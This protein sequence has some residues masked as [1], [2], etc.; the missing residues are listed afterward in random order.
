M[1]GKDVNA[2][3]GSTSSGQKRQPES[4]TREYLCFRCSGAGPGKEETQ[5]TLPEK[6]KVFWGGQMREHGPWGGDWLGI[7]G[8]RLPLQLAGSTVCEGRGQVKEA[9][10]LVFCAGGGTRWE[11]WGQGRQTMK[12]IFCLTPRGWVL[13][14]GSRWE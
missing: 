14:P 5:K 13:D 3:R 1:L 2:G 8:P 10:V 12:A 6:G 4:M 9:W 11:V 7:G